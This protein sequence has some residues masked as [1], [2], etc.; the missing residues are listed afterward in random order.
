[1]FPSLEELGY[2]ID[3]LILFYVVIL[4]PFALPAFEY[5][6]FA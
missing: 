2:P 4:E 6:Y 5:I 1:M 3:F